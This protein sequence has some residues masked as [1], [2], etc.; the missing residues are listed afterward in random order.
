MGGD[1][2][3]PGHGPA[4]SASPEAGAV[5]EPE[6]ARRN[7]WVAVVIF[8]WAS[9]GWMAAL[10]LSAD[11]PFRHP[12][13]AWLG[14]GVAA[15]WAAWFTASPEHLRTATLVVDLVLSFG[16]VM[17]SGYV[18]EPG[19][20][21]GEGPSYTSFYPYTTAIAWGAAQGR[22]AGLTAGLIVGLATILNRPVNGV[23]L[24]DL[25]RGEIQNLVTGVVIFAVTGL[26]TGSVSRVLN[27]S[28]A[29][30]RSVNEAAM[31]ERERAA[32]LEERES[33]ARQIHDSVL[34]SLA[35]VHKRGR[36]LGAQETVQGSEVATLAELARSQEQLLRAMIV[37]PAGT[38]PSGSSS[39]RD[40][41]EAAART[42]PGIPVTVGAVGPIWRP[43]REV[44]EVTAAVR[45][46]L[47]NVVE[48]AGATRASV[49][50]E[51]EGG[52]LTVTIR[53]DGAGFIYREERLRATG[54]LGMLKSMKGRV[55]QLGGAMQVET[56][57]G[58]GTEVEFIIPSRPER[59]G[60]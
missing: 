24:G 39:L 41:L 59:R 40:A 49:F 10:A 7:L 19:A 60:R 25:S 42:V 34:Q 44:E 47:E 15:V 5:S 14:I 26:A 54:K 53:D 27:R 50:A 46:A 16:L 21:R 55:E 6:R 8:R 28:A 32:R 4:P 1:G 57:P 56:T 31:R 17:A 11:Q 58:A 9:I 35:F 3:T 29:Q 51:D 43:V 45:Q 52:T 2:L 13:V 18:V 30:L 23:A 12:A 36:E 33:L 48:H 37:R 22:L 38:A 20:I